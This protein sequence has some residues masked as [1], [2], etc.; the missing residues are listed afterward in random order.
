MNSVVPEDQYYKSLEPEI[1][2]TVKGIDAIV[3]GTK[4]FLEGN[5]FYHGKTFS[6]DWFFI[7]KRINYANMVKEYKLKNILEIG[8]NAGHSAAVFLAAMDKDAS[9]TC[10]DLNDH[11]Y[12]KPCFEY[13]QSKYPQVKQCIVGDSKETLKKTLLENQS[14]LSSFDCVHIDGG[15]DFYTVQ[16]DIEYSH[17]YL[18]SGGILILDDT[19]IGHISGRIPT[20]LALGYTFPFQLPTFVFSHVCF[21]KI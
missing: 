19:Q 17:S 21:K 2:E 16:S 8:F 18:K 4:E 11:S 9:Y 13:L 15:H 12:T 5:C 1:Q 20:I 6:E 10:F 7:Y 3:V 14:L